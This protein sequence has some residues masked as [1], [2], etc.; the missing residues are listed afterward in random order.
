MVMLVLSRKVGE[1][2][3]I[4]NNIKVTVVDVGRGKIRIGI[5]A[6]AEVQIMR[7]ELL[8]RLQ[9]FSEPAESKLACAY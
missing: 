8:Q 9:E 7:E 3:I 2:I 6:P 5:E 4:N 1:S